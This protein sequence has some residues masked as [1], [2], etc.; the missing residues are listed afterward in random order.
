[1]VT[2]GHTALLV[3]PVPSGKITPLMREAL[4]QT[5]QFRLITSIL[6]PPY[7]SEK[8]RKSC[9]QASQ[10]FNLGVLLSQMCR[11]FSL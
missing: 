9:I 3:H 5:V 4:C 2:R 7:H 1:M 11:D 8:G 6:L 10:Y